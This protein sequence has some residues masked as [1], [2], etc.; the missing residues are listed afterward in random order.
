MRGLYI[1]F[2]I[3]DLPPDTFYLDHTQPVDLVQKAVYAA[4]TFFADGLLVSISHLI[5]ALHSSFVDSQSVHNI[6]QEMASSGL[7]MHVSCGDRWWVE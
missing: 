7:S 6:R 3:T 2:F 4:A 5:P 1:A